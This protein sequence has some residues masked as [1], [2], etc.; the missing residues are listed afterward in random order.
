MK[1]T[2]EQRAQLRRENRNH[3]KHLVAVPN[4]LWPDSAGP[5]DLTNDEVRLEVLRSRD[6]LVQ[7]FSPA[8]RSTRRL[9]VNRTDCDKEGN[10]LEGITW[11]ELMRLKREAGYGDYCAVEFY[12]PD[13]DIV[14][15]ANMRHLFLVKAGGTIPKWWTK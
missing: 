15:V 11:D 7:V 13:K 12:P 2:K 9:S 4:T 6:F 3:P 5:Y 8:D 10:W 1:P 14:N